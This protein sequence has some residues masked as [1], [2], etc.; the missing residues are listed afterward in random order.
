MQDYT[1]IIGTIEMRQRGISYGDCRARY[2]I[3]TSTITLIMNR[4]KESGKDLDSLKQMS[5]EEVERLFYPPENVRRKDA[6]VMPD[7]QTVYNRLTAPGSKANL[8]YMWLK[9]K[10]DIPSGYQYTQYCEYFRRFLKKTYGDHALRMVVERI[11]GEKVYID[12]IGDQPE[13]LVDRSTGVM[14]KVHFFVTTVGVSNLVYAEAFENEKLPNFIAGTVHALDSYGAVPKYL[15]PDNLKTAIKKHTRDEL[16]LTSAFQDL[17]SFYDVV[18]LPPPAR[19]PKGKATVEKYVQVLETHL[20]EDLKENLYYSIEDIN[21]D[22]RKKVA[23]INNQKK[24]STSVS[25]MECFLRYDKPQMRSLAG[26]SFSLCDYKYFS[27]VPNNYH[28]LYDDHYYSV[29]YTY[30]DQPAILKATFAEVHICDRNN[31]LICKHHRSYKDFPKYITKEEHM[32]PNHKYYRDVNSKDGA[33]YRR[34]AS[35]IGPYTTQLIDRLL[36][37][38]QHEE[39]AYNSCNG[40]LHMCDKQSHLLIE[41]VSKSCVESGACK[42]TYFKKLLKQRQ[43]DNHGTAGSLPDHSNL[44]G[45]EAYH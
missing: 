34:W 20:L 37:S 11:P 28:L 41:E 45:K 30:Y 44:R 22:V 3:G 6:S 5:S 1:T 36:L 12:W 9:Y 13:I 25:K 31:K 8:F 33:Y 23:A 10:Q 18:V 38:M 39:Q 29:L 26:E 27:R 16:I 15:V 43:N 21:R 2:G 14:K 42:Y 19:K 4:F 24:T 40:I 7:Y 35:A 32:P 17:E